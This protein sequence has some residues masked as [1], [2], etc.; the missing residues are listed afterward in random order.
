MS[1]AGFPE[2]HAAAESL[3]LEMVRDGLIEFAGLSD[4]G[5]F[6]YRL[7]EAGERRAEQLVAGLDPED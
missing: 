6:R 7:T 4:D 3:I 5:E 2:D 1:D